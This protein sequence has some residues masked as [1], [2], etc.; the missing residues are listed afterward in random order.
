MILYNI[1]WDVSPEIFSFLPIRWYGT[2][3]ALGFFIAYHLSIKLYTKEGYPAEWVD[4]L[5]I[6]TMV[7]TIIG[8][9]LG[10]VL[11][12]DPAY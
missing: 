1:W 11:F 4:H 6:Y 5:F 2:F 12:Y 10:H 3:F 9:R 8:A 7:A